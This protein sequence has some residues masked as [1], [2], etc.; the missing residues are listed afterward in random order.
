MYQE[1]QR[2]LAHYQRLMVSAKTIGDERLHETCVKI[3][4]EI[5]VQIKEKASAV[6]DATNSIYPN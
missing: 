5:S 6:T 1:L 4:R 3:T 2:S